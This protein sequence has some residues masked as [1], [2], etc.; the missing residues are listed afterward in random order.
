[1]VTQQSE[2]DQQKL[3]HRAVAGYIEMMIRR[4]EE[5]LN[6]NDKAGDGTFSLSMSRAIFMEKGRQKPGR[7]VF[8]TPIG[9][10]DRCITR[11]D[12]GAQL[13]KQG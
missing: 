12:A 1:M 8:N 5:L 6:L 4:V 13:S 10:I 7:V 3:K 9:P 2:S 11:V